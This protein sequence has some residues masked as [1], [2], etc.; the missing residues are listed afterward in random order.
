MCLHI[1]FIKPDSKQKKHYWILLQLDMKQN[2]VSTKFNSQIKLTLSLLLLHLHGIE[3]ALQPVNIFLQ[4]P[5]L[6]LLS[7]CFTLWKASSWW[8]KASIGAPQATEG[9]TPIYVAVEFGLFGEEHLNHSSH[10]Q[11]FILSCMKWGLRCE[12]PAIKQPT[13]AL[14]FLLWHIWMCLQHN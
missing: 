12:F 5:Y 9:A 6:H 14:P 3:L 11:P 2:L 7:I 10:R 4:L 1:L 8:V 13:Q